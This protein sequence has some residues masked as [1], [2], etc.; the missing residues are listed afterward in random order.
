MKTP[1][2]NIS[3]GFALFKSIRFILI[4]IAFISI[5]VAGYSIWKDTGQI[6]PIIKAI[7]DKIFNPLYTLSEHIN[8]ISLNG[9]YPNDFNF[10]N[11]LWGFL[12]NIYLIFEPLI[13]LYYGLF[14]LFLF[15]KHFI[16]QDNSRPTQSLIATAI[17]YF[18]ISS[19]YVAL[20]TELPLLTPFTAIRNILSYFVKLIS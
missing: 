5:I 20:F 4:S 19:L 6:E 9:I 2:I 15:S 17:I 1:K 8:D 16:I 7:G 13:F 12:V 18:L 10:F 11:N 14:Y 3:K